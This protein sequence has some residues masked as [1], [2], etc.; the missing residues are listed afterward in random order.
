MKAAAELNTTK[1]KS[2]A[3]SEDLHFLFAA[4]K[5]KVDFH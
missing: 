1:K 5:K 4:R 3:V 2:N